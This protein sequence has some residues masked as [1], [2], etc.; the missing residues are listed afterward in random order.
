MTDTVRS[1][2]RDAASIALSRRP[3]RHAKGFQA[4]ALFTFVQSYGELHGESL[5]CASVAQGSP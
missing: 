5:K 4:C 2:P 3:E 1:P